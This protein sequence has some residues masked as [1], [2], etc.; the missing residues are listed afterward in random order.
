MIKNKEEK[1]AKQLIEKYLPDLCNK[2]IFIVS[3]DLKDEANKSPD[4]QN[5]IDNIGIEVTIAEPQE[6]ME[7]KNIAFKKKTDQEFLN[8][9]TK[10]TWSKPVVVDG[11][12][13]VLIGKLTT[14][15]AYYQSQVK[16]LC[17]SLNKKLD[18][19]NTTKNRKYF[20]NNGLFIC[21]EMPLDEEKINEV[22]NLINRIQLNYLK[23]NPNNKIFD[24]VI[25]SAQTIP[26]L[27]CY[28]DMKDK[29]NNKI[30]EKE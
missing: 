6:E 11:G 15:N 13:R 27:I 7:I 14:P 24:F 1:I 25:I 2:G 22:Y 4:L 16:P 29:S 28:F 8:L 17:D 3:D 26:D 19:L 12:F 9:K 30:I 10:G 21:N 5:D 23:N 18:K 20:S